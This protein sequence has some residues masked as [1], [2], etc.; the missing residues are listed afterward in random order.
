MWG[1][2]RVDR[3]SLKENNMNKITTLRITSNV[4]PFFFLHTNT[5]F[6]CVYVYKLMGPSEGI[7]A[8]V[9]WIPKVEKSMSATAIFGLNNTYKKK[10]KIQY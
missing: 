10:K 8:Q 6:N 4:Y 3:V 7:P 1:V 5:H 2:V 9:V